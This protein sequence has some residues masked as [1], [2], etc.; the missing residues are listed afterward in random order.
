MNCSIM[1]KLRCRAI[2]ES[3]SHDNTYNYYLHSDGNLYIGNGSDSMQN[4]AYDINLENA[5]LP[6]YYEGVKIYGTFYRCLGGLPNLRT[7][8]IPRTYRFIGDDLFHHSY[9][10]ETV[11]FEEYSEVQYIGYW[12]AIGS[13]I[14]SFTF[15]SSLKELTIVHSFYGCKNLKS[16]FYQGMI[17]PPY[18]Y[19]TFEGVNQDFKIYVRKD[20]PYDTFGGKSVTKL[21]EP[22]PT[23]VK[24]TCPIKRL[25]LS[26]IFVQ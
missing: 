19:Y 6:A 23:P 10:V 8:F 12:M 4:G 22:P 21:L 16:I 2:M 18:D 9:K 17:N 14:T 13:S 24:C 7:I 5:I 3:I 26:N 1:S 20:Y 11:E 25:F 15:P